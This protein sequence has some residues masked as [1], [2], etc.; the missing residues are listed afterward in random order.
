M[1]T[2]EAEKKLFRDAWL[3]QRRNG[4]GASEAAAALG[5]SPFLT[6]LELYCQKRGLTEGTEETEAM[7]WGTR[8]EPLIAAAYEERTGQ[9]IQ[10]QQVFTRHPQSPHL[11][12]TID[13]VD[14][15]GTIVEFKTINSFSARSLGEQETDAIPEHWVIQAHQQ[16][17]CMVDPT[18]VVF[19]VLVGGQEFRLYEVEWSEKLW[20]HA[21]PRLDEFWRCVQAENPPPVLAPSDARALSR[22]YSECLGDAWVGQDVA[23]MAEE[24]DAL[25]KQIRDLD[26]QRDMVKAHLLEQLGNTRTAV[27]PDGRK[28]KRSVV[29]IPERTVTIKGS[30]SIRLSL[31]KG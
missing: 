17:A 24:W 8:L 22:I 12:A 26:I 15:N 21:K 27:L 6:P 11:F 18:V 19:A 28:L 20:G 13:A 4:I 29:V 5:L 1:S 7:R 2:V 16:M 10:E 14:E 3:L 9:R 23:R 30:Q 25:G 31:S